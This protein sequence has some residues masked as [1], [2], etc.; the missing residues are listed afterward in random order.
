MSGICESHIQA[1]SQ[2]KQNN[3][4]CCLNY[5][6]I[7]LYAFAFPTIWRSKMDM[8]QPNI[9]TPYVYEQHQGFSRIQ[10]AAQ[11]KGSDYSNAI[12]VERGI[13]LDQALDIA[14]SDPEIDYFVF[15]KGFMMVLELPSDATYDSEKDPLH[16]ITQG[17][18]VFDN[19]QLG[20]GYMRVFSQ[21]DVVFFKKTGKWLGSAPG[22]AD[23]YEKTEQ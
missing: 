19:G 17:P 9:N 15:T 4:F 21:G 5:F 10:D 11:Y 7:S 2:N 20:E 22:L 23:V 8:Q 18:Y 16:L 14:K 12:R 3:I 6:T 1:A 13:T